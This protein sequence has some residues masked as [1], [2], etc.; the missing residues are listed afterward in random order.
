[1][2]GFLLGGLGSAATAAGMGTLGAGLTA[3][4]S[5]LGGGGIP[6]M[7]GSAAGGA[8][9]AAGGASMPFGMDLSKLINP[10]SENLGTGSGEQKPA[11]GLMGQMQKGGQEQL[12]K[13]MAQSSAAAQQGAT[14]GPRQVDVASLMNIIN[15]RPR[16]G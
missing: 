16:L 12:S 15:S 14:A 4:G 1:M 6:G 13:M 11:D 5:M 7:G 8:A 3:A 9:G 2:L 10:V